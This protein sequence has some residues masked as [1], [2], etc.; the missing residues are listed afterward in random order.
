MLNIQIIE[1]NRF[2]KIYSVRKIFHAIQNFPLAED[3]R[4]LPSKKMVHH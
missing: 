2:E 3:P 4:E 1:K